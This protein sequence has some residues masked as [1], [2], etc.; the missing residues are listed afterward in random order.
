MSD[1]NEK[2]KKEKH[3]YQLV[4]VQGQVR[5]K[6][7]IKQGPARVYCLET[8][9]RPHGERCRGIVDFPQKDSINYEDSCSFTVS[10]MLCV[11]VPIAFDAVAEVSRGR[12][13]CGKPRPTPCKVPVYKCAC[14]NKEKML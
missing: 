3:V 4:K 8:D 10:Q 2:C 5:V 1:Q 7:K 9:I 12:I 13:V 6:P 11:E 14:M